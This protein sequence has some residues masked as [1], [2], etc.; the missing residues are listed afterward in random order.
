MRWSNGWCEDRRSGRSARSATALAARRAGISLAATWR[1]HTE[2]T[3]RSTSSG[4]TKAWCAK[5]SRAC[6][7][8]VPSSP[9]ATARTLAST[10]IT[11]CPNV[12][13]GTLEGNP[14]T[15]V[16]GDAVQNLVQSWL[17]RVS[18][19]T[20]SKVFLQG[21]MRAGGPLAQHAVSVLW[22]VFDLHARHGAILAP[23]APK[24]KREPSPS[25]LNHMR[26]R[27]LGMCRCARLTA[28][29]KIV[30]AVGQADPR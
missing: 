7:P 21:L 17:V 6:W 23:T 12:L 26:D 14:A 27:K 16:T 30:L 22:N 28:T 13:N 2:T 20:A 15:T 25:T 24:C 9:S 5:R 18:D 19:Q 4:A 10:T 29:V 1:R 11:F 8:S 3:S